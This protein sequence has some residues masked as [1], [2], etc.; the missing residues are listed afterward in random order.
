MLASAH[1][2]EAERVARCMAPQCIRECRVVAVT[3]STTEAGT[4]RWQL[5]LRRRASVSQATAAPEVALRAVSTRALAFGARYLAQPS[6]P[7]LPRQGLEAGEG[8]CTCCSRE[9]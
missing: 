3:S 7:E 5:W 1:A 2:V 4:C 6:V 9:W 8:E